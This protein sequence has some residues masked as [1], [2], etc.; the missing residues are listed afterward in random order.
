M[1]DLLQDK[2]YT[3]ETMSEALQAT[4]RGWATPSVLMSKINNDRKNGK[5]SWPDWDPKSSRP[6][7]SGSG[8][9]L[10][11]IIKKAEGS[12]PDA[13]RSKPKSKRLSHPLYSGLELPHTNRRFFAASDFILSSN[14][15]PSIIGSAQGPHIKP[16]PNVHVADFIVSAPT[17]AWEYISW[18]CCAKKSSSWSIPPTA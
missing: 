13:K 18:F 8:R 14:G 9:G 3:Y 12:S 5:D 17:G 10:E 7:A 1:H 2:K 11:E 15:S 6:K 4:G 16:D